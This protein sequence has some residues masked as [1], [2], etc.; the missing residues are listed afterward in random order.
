MDILLSGSKGFWSDIFPVVLP[1]YWL[2]KVRFNA[3]SC[4]LLLL[5]ISVEPQMARFRSWLTSFSAYDFSL[6]IYSLDVDNFTAIYRIIAD[7]SCIP[8]KELINPFGEVYYQLDCYVV[9][10]FGLIEMT[11]QIAWFEKVSLIIV[12]S[13]YWSPTNVFFCWV[14]APGGREAV[15]SWHSPVK[16]DVHYFHR[17]PA[18]IVYDQEPSDPA[19]ILIKDFQAL[20]M[21]WWLKDETVYIL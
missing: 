1:T 18:T 16:Y 9:L 13:F 8:V 21:A 15:R 4:A 17:I 5:G 14:M 19:S 10:F 12:L 7:I 20:T 2:P 11:A 3:S 6:L